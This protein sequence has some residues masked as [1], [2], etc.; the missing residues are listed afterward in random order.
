MRSPSRDL[1]TA[2]PFWIVT[3]VTDRPTKA[4]QDHRY[5]AMQI[6]TSQGLRLE[7]KAKTSPDLRVET[8]VE[9]TRSLLPHLQI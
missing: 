5:E 9:D 4:S 3:R 6:K 7:V 8:T 2:M 1:P